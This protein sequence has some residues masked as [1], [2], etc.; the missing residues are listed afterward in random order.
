MANALGKA[1]KDAKKKKKKKTP[2]KKNTKGVGGISTTQVM[3]G[4][5]G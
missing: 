3:L 4:T 2:P 5:R 1:L